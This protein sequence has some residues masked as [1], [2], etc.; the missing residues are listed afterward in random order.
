MLSF[1]LIDFKKYVISKFKTLHFNIVD[2]LNVCPGQPD[3]KFT[4]FVRKKKGVLRA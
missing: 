3:E 1:I 4:G 2:H